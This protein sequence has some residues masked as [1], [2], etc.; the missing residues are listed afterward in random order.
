MSG[1]AQ[2]YYRLVLPL[3]DADKPLLSPHP[4][5]WTPISHVIW[6]GMPPER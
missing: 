4:L 1:R 2:R 6:D 5:A 3:E